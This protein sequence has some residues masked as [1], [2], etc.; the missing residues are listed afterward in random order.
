MG[1]VCHNTWMRWSSWI[2]LVLTAVAAAGCKSNGPTGPTPSDEVAYSAIA[3]SDGIGYG[4]SVPCVPFDPECPSGTGYVYVLK[5]RLQSD[6][7]TVALSNRALPGA[8]L[9]PAIQGLARNVGH[10]II[11]NFLDHEAPF[12]AN[13]STHVTIFAGG[14]DANVIAENVRAGLAGSDVR[15]FIDQHVNQWGSDLTELIRRVRTRA[16]TSRIVALNLPNL[17]AA[18]YASAMTVQERSVL[19]RIAVTLTDRVNGLRSQNV[20]V[21]DLMCDARIYER[22]RFSSDGFHPN[23]PGYALMADLSYP[24]LA[25]GSAASPSSSCPQRT[26]FPVF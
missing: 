20:L 18:P 9:S 7:R 13:N 16:P 23:D 2:C 17:A 5:R 4:G 10:D 19:Q 15:G 3:A 6:G 26:L 1:R 8:V 12:I 21:V 14:N 24:A 25:N 22:G 11:A